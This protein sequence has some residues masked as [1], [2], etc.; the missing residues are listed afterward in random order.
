[1]KFNGKRPRIFSDCRLTRKHRL[2]RGATIAVD[3][4]GFMKY[5]LGS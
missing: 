4:E 3:P 2:S 5:T 1:M